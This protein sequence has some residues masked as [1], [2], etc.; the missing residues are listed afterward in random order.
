MTLHYCFT[1]PAILLGYEVQQHGWE[2]ED[3]HQTTF[4]QQILIQN[5]NELV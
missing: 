3:R 1:F 4:D 5:K 2:E